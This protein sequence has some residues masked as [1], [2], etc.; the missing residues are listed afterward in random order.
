[1][2]PAARPTIEEWRSAL[3]DLRRAG[4][5]WIGPCP[6]CGGDDRFRVGPHGAYCRQCCPSG[7]PRYGALVR[8]VFGDSRMPERSQPAPPAKTTSSTQP[9]ALR[10]VRES[11]QIAGT[12]A[13]RYLA[14]RGLGDANAA[15]LRFH[16]AVR[17]RDGTFPA[18]IAPV[19]P[20]HGAEP[21]ACNCTLLAD[22]GGKAPV[23]PS[24]RSYGPVGQGAAYLGATPQGAIVVAEGVENALAAALIVGE[25]YPVSTA[26]TGNLANWRPPPWC[27][28]A[29]LF[30]DGDAAG[31]AAAG[32]L[33]TSMDAVG[34][35]LEVRWLHGDD[36]NDLWLKRQEAQ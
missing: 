36:A 22:N 16:P 30:A 9:Y 35:A 33:L 20:D 28:R 17:T 6:L 15:A 18:M 24:K 26:G 13:E 25:G 4:K 21:V 34:F 2:P 7:G 5:D 27:D 12:L 1:M 3:P 29:I 32:R 8:A 11:A 10:I 19:R 14:K 23:Q 31:R